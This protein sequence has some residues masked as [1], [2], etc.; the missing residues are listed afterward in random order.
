MHAHMYSSGILAKK[1]TY[2]RS[3]FDIPPLT[4]GFSF[5]E[6][7]LLRAHSCVAFTGV[8]SVQG[9]SGSPNSDKSSSSGY[10]GSGAC[11]ICYSTWIDQNFVWVDEACTLSHVWSRCGD[12]RRVRML[13]LSDQG[14]LLLLI[15]WRCY[16]TI[17]ESNSCAVVAF[18]F[19]RCKSYSSIHTLPLAMRHPTFPP[20]TS[21]YSRV[22]LEFLWAQ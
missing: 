2:N 3:T 5:S 4:C 17:L 19:Y 6:R 12:F 14:T 15:S 9:L 10:S 11:R 22:L 13:H 1:Q 18:G 16:I 20:R 8:R 21:L 7:V